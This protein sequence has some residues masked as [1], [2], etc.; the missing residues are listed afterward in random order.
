MLIHKFFHRAQKVIVQKVEDKKKTGKKSKSD[1]EVESSAAEDKKKTEAEQDS[2]KE[3]KSKK[4]VKLDMHLQQIIVDANEPYVWIY[5]PIPLKT[6]FIGLGLVVGAVLICLFP[7][8]PKIVRTY[9]YYLSIA[10]AGFLFFIIGLAVL[11]FVIF[12]LVWAMTLGKHH[13]WILPN[14]TEDVGF[15]A[16]FWPLYMH[17]FKGTSDGETDKT[18]S[19]TQKESS[20]PSK[21]KNKSEEKEPLL[22]KEEEEDQEEDSSASQGE[23]NP[24]EGDKNGSENGFEIL[25]T[26]ED[27]EAETSHLKSS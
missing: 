20:S 4:K 18:S 1:A 6:W 19:K 7:L 17:E 2:K 11:R 15:F 21:K 10:A 13:F 5:D 12:C 24:S 9:V 26:Q 23:S 3:K 14:L 22:S 16:S 25:E 8:W 27:L